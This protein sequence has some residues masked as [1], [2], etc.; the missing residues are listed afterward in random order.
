VIVTAKAPI[1]G[2]TKTRLHP[3]LHD[4]ALPETVAKVLRVGRQAA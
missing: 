1:P 4:P 2:R 3:L